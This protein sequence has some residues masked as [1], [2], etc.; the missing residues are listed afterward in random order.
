MLQSTGSQAQRRT[1][2]RFDSLDF[3]SPVENPDI[4]VQLKCASRQVVVV[5]TFDGIIFYPMVGKHTCS[6]SND[7]SAG[8]AFVHDI[9]REETHHHNKPLVQVCARL[10]KRTNKA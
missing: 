5:T 6:S 9:Y 2:D 7:R 10:Q 8:G 3:R 1:D 4:S